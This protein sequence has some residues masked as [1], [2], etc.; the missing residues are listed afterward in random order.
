M[1]IGFAFKVQNCSAHDVIPRLRQVADGHGYTGDY[2]E[3]SAVI[4]LCRAGD[5]RFEFKYGGMQGECQTNVVGAGF[6]AAAI[7]FLDEL[8]RETDLLYQVDDETDYYSHRDFQRLRSEHFYGWLRNLVEALA[9]HSAKNRFSTFCVCWDMGLY[10]PQEVP[11]SIASPLGR[12]AIESLVKQCRQGEEGVADLARAFFVWNELEQDALFYRNSALVLLWEA[13][14]FM[15]SRRSEADAEVNGRIIELLETAMRLDPQLP[16]PLREYY[17]LCELAEHEA[18]DTAAVVEMQSEFPIGYRRDKVTE[19][20]G[21]LAMEIEG[22]FLYT[23]ERENRDHVYY[24]GLDENWHSIRVSAFTGVEP[25]SDFDDD[26]FR[27]AMEPPLI[28]PV[29]EGRC[30]AVL[31]GTVKDKEGQPFYQVIAEVLSGKQVTLITLSFDRLEEKEW[32][33]DFLKALKARVER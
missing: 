27:G 14:Y 22:H 23:L 17:L 8:I 1:G 6:H 29:R 30:K 16:M 2:Q 25:R 28:F 13:C 15:P 5:I 7:A 4:S 9:E 21:N 19:R 24:D 10:T 12:F 3:R 33:F 18:L 26:L 32:A 11:G 31:Y 20:L